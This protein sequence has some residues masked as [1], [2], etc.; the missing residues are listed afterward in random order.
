MTTDRDIAPFI[1]S[2]LRD[3]PDGPAEHVLDAAL[4]IV[5]STPQRSAARWSVRRPT[6]NTI[7]RLGVAAAVLA[8]AVALGYTIVQNVGDRTPVPQTPD[9]ASP[10]SPPAGALPAELSRI[11]IGETRDVPGIQV[12]DRLVLDLTQRML[13]LH[14]DYGRSALHSAASAESGVLR[15]QTVVGGAA[16]AEG[17]VGIYPYSF[18]PGGTVLTLDVEDDDCSVRSG[19]LAGEWRLSGC[20]DASNWCLGVLEAGTQH[21]LFFDPFRTGFGA[22][23]TRYGAMTY[24]IPDGWANADDRTHFYTLLRA[25]DYTE[26]RPFDCLDCPD[27]LWI[28]ANPQ[29]VESG[30]SE[31]ADANV[32]GSVDA[33][34]EWLRAHPGLEV[35]DGEAISVDGRPTIV[36][37]IAAPESWDGLC[38]DEEL[39][40]RFVPLFAH[41]GYT[42]GVRAGDRTGLLLVEIDADSAMLIA[43]EADPDHLESVIAETRPIIDSIRLTAP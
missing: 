21:S 8:M 15:V 42:F 38:R 17:D 32:G 22:A 1:R 4:A 2:W 24:E 9:H 3:D 11:F 31:A 19:A 16:C 41:P 14:T 7:V 12:G 30:C 25:E 36:L 5:E 23:V 35:L 29:A 40:A 20:R 27:G 6:M 26:P 13:R 28:G 34:V 39:D 33:L 37:D 18:S 10:T 43:V